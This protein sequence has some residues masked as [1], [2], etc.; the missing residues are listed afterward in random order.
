M[1]K[2]LV[3]LAAGLLAFGAGS[4]R[5]ALAQNDPA[6]PQQYPY[7]QPQQDRNI[8]ASRSRT[9]L[10]RHR[11][12]IRRTRR[13]RAPH[14][15]HGPQGQAPP[16]PASQQSSQIQPGVARLVSFM[17]MSRSSVA[18]MRNGGRHPE[19]TGRAG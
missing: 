6:Y 7:G 18:T 9:R 2:I 11:D 15:R 16:P 8:R 14:L 17:V 5:S 19:H 1:K 4:L 10:R 12:N 13:I 3:A